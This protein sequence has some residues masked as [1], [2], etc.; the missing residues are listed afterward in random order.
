MEK[1]GEFWVPSKDVRGTRNRNKVARDFADGRGRVGPIESAIETIKKTAPELDLANMSAFDGGANVGS[2]TRVMAAHFGTVISL[3]PAPDTFA[4][5]EA[6]V[7]DWGLLPRVIPYMAAVGDQR[8][9]ISMGRAWGR[10]SITSKINGKGN[11]PAVPLDAFGR[12]DVA[13]IK[14]DIEGYEEKALI[15]AQQTIETCR[16]FIM[17]EV[18]EDEPGDPLAAHRRLLSMGYKDIHHDG[19][20]WLY[21]PEG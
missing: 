3:E 4:C 9:Y 21:Q 20:N 8:D 16:P 19:I 17:M 2:Y 15:G 14:L 12:S 7:H 18:K 1:V 10:R 6:N 5:L 13:L 11:I